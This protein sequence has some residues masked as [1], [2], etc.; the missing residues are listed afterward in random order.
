MGAFV[1]D[2]LGVLVGE[3]VVGDL[4]GPGV[5]GPVG[6]DVG[7]RVGFGVGLNV[8]LNV[9]LDVVSG[10]SKQANSQPDL[11]GQCENCEQKLSLEISNLA[12][13]AQIISPLQFMANNHIVI[14]HALTPLATPMS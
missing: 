10:K 14:S 8:G 11:M 6:L 12:I 3:A 7:Y 2:L 5:V 13:H 9:G 1:G 4:V